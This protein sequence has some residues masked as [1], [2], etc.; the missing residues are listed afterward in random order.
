[1]D[2]HDA[3]RYIHSLQEGLPQLNKNER[4][5]FLKEHSE[6]LNNLEIEYNN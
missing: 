3:R 2:Y 1:M 4:S 5:I 6:F